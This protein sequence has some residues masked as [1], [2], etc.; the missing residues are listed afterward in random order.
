MKNNKT[1]RERYTD[2]KQLYKSLQD[3]CEEMKLR[4][5]RTLSFFVAYTRE[6]R[7]QRHNTSNTPEKLFLSKRHNCSEIC[8][9]HV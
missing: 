8:D 2:S 4:S 7:T 9:V 1:M 6:E 3:K 5:Y